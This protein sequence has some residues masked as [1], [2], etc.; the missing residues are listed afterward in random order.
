[1]TSNIN[2]NYTYT[3]SSNESD[4]AITIHW[5]VNKEIIT[6]MQTAAV[7]LLSVTDVAVAASG[8]LLQAQIM[9]WI[10]K[11]V[12]SSQPCHCVG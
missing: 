7:G 5:L 12:S 11:D 3:C 9:S 4:L 8:F 10:S 2:V 6:H 1:M